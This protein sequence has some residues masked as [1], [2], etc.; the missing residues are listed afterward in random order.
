MNRRQT[1]T[2]YISGGKNFETD[3]NVWTA[4]ETFLQL[5]E[6]FG[7]EA[8]QEVFDEYNQLENSERPKEQQDKNDQWMIRFSKTVGKNLGPFFRAWNI[9]VTEKALAEVSALPDWAED[10]MVK[11]R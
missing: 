3:W 10:P 5:Q 7:W 9:P 4:L 2:K 11:Y 6:A 8:F 1:F